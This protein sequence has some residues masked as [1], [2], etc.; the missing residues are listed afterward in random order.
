MQKVVLPEIAAGAEGIET[1]ERL[2]EV[3]AEEPHVLFAVTES[4][5]LEFG[6]MLIMFVLELPVQ[7]TGIV[8]V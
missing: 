7:P 6:T 4:V 3:F 8:Q 2:K 1:E 5:P